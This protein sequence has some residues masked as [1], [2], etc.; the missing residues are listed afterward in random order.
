MATKNKIN[1]TMPETAKRR[2]P[3]TLGILEK[4][5]EYPP[6]FKRAGTDPMTINKAAAKPSSLFEDTANSHFTFSF[7]L[8][9]LR[10]KVLWK[11]VLITL[12]LLRV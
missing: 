2:L 7:V 8:W 9:Q 1:P 12:L 5:Y 6:T 11:N 10:N 3:P 4:G